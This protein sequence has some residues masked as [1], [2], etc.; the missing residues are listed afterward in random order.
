[1]NPQFRQFLLN[2]GFS[3][4][5]IKGNSMGHVFSHKTNNDILISTKYIY[6]PSSKDIFEQHA[7]FWNRNSESFFI[8]ISDYNSY[9]INT[10]EKPDSER[11]LKNSICLQ[12][13]NYGINSIGFENLDMELISKDYVDSAYFFDFIIK[14]QKKSQTV[15]KDLLL[16][17]LALKS[18]LISNQNQDFIYIL[19]LRCLFIKY[20]EDRKIFDNNYL[21]NILESKNPDKLKEAFCNVAKI[22]GDVFKYD[23]F[24]FSDL[25]PPYLDKLALFFSSDYRSSQL[26]LFPYKFDEIPIE[27]IS[28]VYEA[29]LNDT[30]KKGRGIYYT[31]SFLVKFMLADTFAKK[32]ELNPKST[33]IDPAV[34][35]GA[36]LVE[37]FKMIQKAHGN[38]LD[39]DAKKQ[40]LETQLFGIDVD[41]KALQIASFSLYLALLETEDPNFIKSEIERSNP[42]LPTLIGKTLIVGNS[43][44]ENI[45]PDQTFD[46]VASN[47][48][49]GSV[50][51]DDNDIFIKERYA[52]SNKNNEFPEYENVADYERSQA[53]LALV[54]KWGNRN[55]IYTMVV[56]NS[57]FLNDKSESFRKEFL[58]K[59][60]I[61]TFY[62]LSHYNKILFKKTNIGKINGR[63]IELG[64]SEPCVVINF[65]NQ[66]TN[67]NSFKYI[68]PKLTDIAE[69]LE[70]IHFT[71]QDSFEIRQ[72]EFIDKD[73]LWK[74][75]V[76]SDI[77]AHSLIFDKILKQKKLNVEARV[78][79]QP[80]SKMKSGDTVF[81]KP[82]IG[83]NDF[84]QFHLKTK[85]LE[86]F[87]WNQNLRRRPVNSVFYGPRIVLS[88]MPTREDNFLLRAIYLEEEIINKHNM[89]SLKIKNN[90]SFILD[91][92][93]YLGI[94]NSKLMGFVL[95]QLS[96]QWGKGKT[97]VNL[98][99]VDL[100]NLPLIEIEDFYLLD[101]FNDVIK[102]IQ[103]KKE[104]GENVTDEINL[105]NEMVFDL[106]K[107]T[108][109]EKEIIKEF[110][111][112]NVDREGVEASFVRAK[113]I[114]RYYNSFKEAFSLILSD[115]N[116]LNAS[117]HISKNLGA[118]ISFSI[119]EKNSGIE[120][121]A[122]TSLS[123]L[124][125]VKSKQMNAADS[126]KVLFEGKVKLYDNNHFYIIKSNQF[127]D[128]TVRQAIK[129]AKE[130]INLFINKLSLVDE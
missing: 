17:L 41:P 91:Y 32:V 117:Y 128:W 130:E 8:A 123:I 100:E 45:F 10:K 122:D 120:F 118:V 29:F 49:W 74:V 15:D 121:K 58:K 76:N 125:F 102:T 109:Y 2:L 88:T 18:D 25:L 68:S 71:N 3:E 1:M 26:K 106:Y 104:L 19:I 59:N 107:L 92:L 24:N 40:I 81:L 75:L 56:K 7:R 37:A 114:E 28:Q 4:S 84:S 52:L 38:Q 97:W 35:S 48:P 77:E 13:F 78:G 89:I 99:N 21:L 70:I 27:I 5:E 22:N 110:Y 57:I 33:I 65:K 90:N 23:N 126:L 113:D 98:R 64:A 16:N 79:F 39:F 20:L 36:F 129:D 12:S 53:F 62:E 61:E 80:Q 101:K 94:L 73:S 112:V 66:S 111:E 9:V 11:P 46:C 34:G 124:N 93:P 105:L 60:S 44:F 96:V 103:K 31:P 67:N 47:P 127:K 115:D 50:P 116:I 87:N 55:T 63:K 108:I 72:S 54:S 51:T 86:V 42:I 30:D 82:I 69:Q 119:I 83:P 6:T 85:K 43:I 14:N 95:F